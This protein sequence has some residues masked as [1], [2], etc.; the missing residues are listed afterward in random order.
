MYPLAKNDILKRASNY[1]PRLHKK[2][3]EMVAHAFLNKY[4]P[5]AANYP[6]PVPIEEIAR[7]RI[8]LTVL[9]RSISEDFDVFGMM[10]FSSGYTEIYDRETS[11][12]LE[13]PVRAGTMIIDPDTLTKRN[14]GCMNNTIAHECVHW[15]LHRPYHEF[16]SYHKCTAEVQNESHQG[17][18]TDEDWMEWQANSIAPRILMPAT[19]IRYVYRYLDDKWNSFSDSYK[20]PYLDRALWI[21][22]NL[23][24]FYKVS[25]QSAGLR[26]EEMKMVSEGT[27]PKFDENRYSYR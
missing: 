3:F 16:M 17:R 20:R 9:K 25:K 10:C 19:T 24:D 15:D 12:Y 11:E 14:L 5:D 21:R 7:S 2:A 18:W 22:K 13:L 8:G 6:M 27:F 23:A 1:I 4:F 26:M